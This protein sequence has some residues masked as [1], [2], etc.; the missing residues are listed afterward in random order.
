MV[1]RRGCGIG[2]DIGLLLRLCSDVCED[3]FIALLLRLPGRFHSEGCG[4]P[5]TGKKR[6]SGFIGSS[7]ESTVRITESG[8]L[9]EE[10]LMQLLGAALLPEYVD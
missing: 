4:M 5:G 1:S 10:S 2:A 7:G 6:R 8:D 9:C 3:F